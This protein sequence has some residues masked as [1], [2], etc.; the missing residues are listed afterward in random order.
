MTYICT[1]TVAEANREA[2]KI[3][4]SK[5]D[6]IYFGLIRDANA[7]NA[8]WHRKA[9]EAYLA[10]VVNMVLEIKDRMERRF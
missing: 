8:M 5:M 9:H 3:D 10:C 1:M 6:D 7:R 4:R 2:E